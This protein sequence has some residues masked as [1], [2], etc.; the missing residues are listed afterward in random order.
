MTMPPK[1]V[2]TSKFFSNDLC[3]PNFD[4][5]V[6][7]RISSAALCRLVKTA[8]NIDPKLKGFIREFMPEVH[9]C[10]YDP[11]V[12]DFGSWWQLSTEKYHGPDVRSKWKCKHIISNAELKEIVR[13]EVEFQASLRGLKIKSTTWQT[14][15][16][17]VVMERDQVSRQSDWRQL[18]DRELMQAFPARPTSDDLIDL[19]ALAHSRRSNILLNFLNLVSKR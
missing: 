13:I 8:K 15:S 4:E 3:V 5:Q 2:S 1:F 18:G 9:F 14:N 7:L 16:C 19:H 10:C 17:E 6:T 11:S 12:T